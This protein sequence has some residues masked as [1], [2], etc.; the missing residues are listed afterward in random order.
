MQR[1]GRVIGS[2]GTRRVGLSRQGRIII[3]LSTLE[4]EGTSQKVKLSTAKI[5]NE[6]GSDNDEEML[7]LDWQIWRPT[8]AW[9]YSPKSQF[10]SL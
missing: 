8:H 6:C 3:P 2:M 1:L 9:L 4:T 5:M 10:G 7:F